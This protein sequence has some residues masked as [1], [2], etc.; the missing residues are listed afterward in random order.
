MSFKS[1]LTQMLGFTSSA[2][3]TTVANNNQYLKSFA[4]VFSS[5]RLANR[6]LITS[7]NVSILLAFLSIS[8]LDNKLADKIFFILGTNVFIAYWLIYLMSSIFALLLNI[9]FTFVETRNST[10]NSED[11]TQLK[12]LLLKT[13]PIYN[14]SNKKMEMRRVPLYLIYFFVALVLF[15]L[16][17]AYESLIFIPIERISESKPEFIYKFN[18]SS[19]YTFS[20]LSVFTVSNIIYSNKIRDN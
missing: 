6:L 11:W 16:W 17:L 8:G 14:F 20:T 12:Q 18:S 5:S 3:S 9:Y 1:R 2:Q 19:F 13:R 4:D 7:C 10:L 15:G